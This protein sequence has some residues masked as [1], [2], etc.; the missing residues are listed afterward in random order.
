[1]ESCFFTKAHAF[2]FVETL[3]G[4]LMPSEVNEDIK[5]CVLEEEASN[6]NSFS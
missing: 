6:S 5:K 2:I 4:F 1:M 3:K